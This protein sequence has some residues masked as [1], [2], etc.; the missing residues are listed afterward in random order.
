MTP[1]VT[2][3]LLRRS[4]AVLALAALVFA[5]TSASAMAALQQTLATSYQTNGT[6]HSIVRSDGVVYIG[7]AFTSVRPAGSALG[8][9]ETARNHL[10]AFDAA[11]GVLLPWNPNANLTV[12][13]L[14]MGPGGGTVYAGGD[15]SLVGGK[16]RAHVA[17]ISAAGAGAVLNWAP[18]ANG[19]SVYAIATMGTRV[20]LGG[21]F[22]QIGNAHRKRLAAISTAGKLLPWASH[23]GPNHAVRAL[24]ITPNSSRI[25][26]G[27]LF[28][29]VGGTKSP[30]IAALSASTGAITPW[31]SHP[32]YEL[33]SFAATSS[34]LYAAGG[35]GGGHI[36]KYNLS[37]GKLVWTASP[38]GDAESVSIYHNLL[39]VGG[40]FRRVGAQVRNHVAALDLQ[41]G[42]VD[43]TWAPSFNQVLG[44]WPVLGYGQDAYAGGDFTR[45]GL[46][47]Q[48]GLAH[49]QDSVSDTTAPTLSTLPNAHMTVGSTVGSSVPVSLAWRGHDNLSGICRYRVHQQIN[50]GAVTGIVPARPTNTSVGRAIIPGTRVYHFS[51]Q[52]TDCSDN[53]PGFIAGNTVRIVTFQNTNSAIKYSAGWNRLRSPGTSGGTINSTSKKNA[54]AKLTFTGRQI[55][56]VASKSA[57]RGKARVYIDGKLVKTVDLHSKTLQR[58]RVVYTRGWA[59]DGSHTI[60]IVNL[61]TS[62]RPAIDIDSLLALR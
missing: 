11:S 38:D 41:S 26:V 35:G 3:G 61:A 57:L 58:R 42:K 34:S 44:V 62:G 32:K 39:L 27:G 9:N 45:V 5:A 25:I 21:E 40:H 59:T 52:P 8:V 10:A 47:D 31:A 55:A 23:N 6:V 2:P 54:S 7:G 13:T 48:Q 53:T 15:F 43:L 24:L 29:L 36:P 30:H 1:A 16:S 37:N 12:R 60:R 51:V 33:L 56:W 14:A 22:N 46:V 4:V 19:G 18:R 20:F 49:F 17:A 28:T 50:A